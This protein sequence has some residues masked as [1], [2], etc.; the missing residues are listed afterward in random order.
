MKA[1]IS[2]KLHEIADYHLFGPGS[3]PADEEALAALWRVHRQYGLSEA[4]PEKEETF[5]DS[6]I[7][8]ECHLEMMTIFTGALEL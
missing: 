4:V 2:R 5:R 3:W 6:A 7:G 1:E 8:I